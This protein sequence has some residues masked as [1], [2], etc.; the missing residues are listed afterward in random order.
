MK[1]KIQKLKKESNA[2]QE[3]VNEQIGALQRENI[4]LF[5]SL[6]KPI[7]D[8]VQATN[9]FYK[10][11]KYREDLDLFNTAKQNVYSNLTNL[12]MLEMK[13]RT[14]ERKIKNLSENEIKQREMNRYYNFNSKVNLIFEDTCADNN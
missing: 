4:D 5:M 2:A 1:K 6:K 8:Y 14:D 11:L 7:Q 13:L 10:I 12:A 3:M 9:T